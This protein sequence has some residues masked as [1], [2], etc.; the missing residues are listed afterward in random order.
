MGAVTE[1][2]DQDPLLW[3]DDSSKPNGTWSRYLVT[4]IVL[5]ISYKKSFALVLYCLLTSKVFKS[6][7]LATFFE[8]R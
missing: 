5:Q 3:V 7:S 1:R 4:P 8:I 6:E 2:T